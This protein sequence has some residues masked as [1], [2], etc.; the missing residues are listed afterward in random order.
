M[1]CGAFPTNCALLGTNLELQG[2]IMRVKAG[3]RAGLWA[4]DCPPPHR[5]L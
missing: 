4:G 2:E 5:G 3:V 1:I